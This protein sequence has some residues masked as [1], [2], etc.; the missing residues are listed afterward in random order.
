MELDDSCDRCFS[1]APSLP[2]SV[3]TLNSSR[4]SGVISLGERGEGNLPAH[5]GTDTFST[6]RCISAIPATTKPHFIVGA[7]KNTDTIIAMLVVDHC[8]HVHF[9]S[10]LS[11]LF[12]QPH[13][14][15]LTSHT[16]GV[17]EYCTLCRFFSAN[18]TQYSSLTGLRAQRQAT[19]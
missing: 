7:Q 13:N 9:L 8:V 11:T 16:N 1:L 18:V 6:G 12:H 15:F 2:R 5:C 19:R 3:L 17:S 10:N 4:E 14:S